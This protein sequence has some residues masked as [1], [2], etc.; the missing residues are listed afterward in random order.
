MEAIHLF[1]IGLVDWADGQIDMEEKEIT[2]SLIGV[3]VQQL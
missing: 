2:P 1:M 3:R